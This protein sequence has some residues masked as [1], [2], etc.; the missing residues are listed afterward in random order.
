VPT[1]RVS[2][3]LTAPPQAVWDVVSDPWHQVRW[4]PRVVRMEAV[5]DGRF[6]QVLGTARGRGVRADFRVVE[7]LAPRLLRWEQELEGSPFQRL[8][9]EA[10]TAI[11]LEPADGDAA[12]NVTIELRQRL[13]GWSRLAPFLFKRAARRQLADAL[14]GLDAAVSPPV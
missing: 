10:V 8:L 1:T 3:T 9:A 5:E 14:A 11:A 7:A 12:T 2:R 6:T 13:L 4:W